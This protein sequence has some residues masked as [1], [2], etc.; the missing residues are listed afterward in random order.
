MKTKIL[1]T[2]EIEI[3]LPSLPD[4]VL[5]ANK[6]DRIQLCDLT[7]D[8]VREIGKQWSEAFVL[9]FRVKKRNKIK[10]IN[11]NLVVYVS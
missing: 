7:E 9:K 10:D 11:K 1:V 2:T 4:F 5:S 3:T 8:Q 6:Q